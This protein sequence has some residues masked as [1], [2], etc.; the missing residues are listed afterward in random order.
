MSAAVPPRGSSL[1][2]PSP[3]LRPLVIANPAARSGRARGEIEAI[4]TSLQSRIGA[5]DLA[6]TEH[7]GH[8][9]ELA[10]RARAEGRALVISVGGDGVLSEVINGLLRRPDAPD[11]A[12]ATAAASPAAE[13]L[14]TLGIVAAGTGGDFGRSLGIAPERTAYLDAI[15]GGRTRLV[16]LGRARFVGTDG[17]AVER[18]FVNVLSAGIGG[19]VDRYTAAMPAAVPGRAAYGAA[20]LAAVVTCRRRRILCRATLADG[21][22]FERVLTTYA[23]VIANGHTFGG[24]MKV[25]PAAR[26]DDGLLDVVLVETPTKLTM[27]RHFLSIY[28]GDHLTKPGVSAF[29]CTRV[30]L[31]AADKGKAIGAD[32]RA[33]SGD[34]T[35][36]ARPGSFFP[37]DVDGDALG[38]LPLTVEVS[39][40]RLRVLA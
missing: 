40:A 38:D 17:R 21:S 27:L 36:T 34:V 2:G 9:T 32:R 20:T 6:V 31:R 30:E 33:G 7:S 8:A 13:T 16:D 11:A 37:L 39:P 18:S 26:V 15:A 10:A 24:G 3:V 22:T 35:S 19:L 1:L 14:P 23:V 12:G 28:R 25:A 29:A 5:V 4:V